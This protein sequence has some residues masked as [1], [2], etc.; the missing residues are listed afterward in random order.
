L[1]YPHLKYDRCDNEK[2]KKHI[3]QSAKEKFDND[4]APKERFVYDK[5]K[6][7]DYQ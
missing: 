7:C 2:E 3:D 5:D 4:E 6:K 1:L